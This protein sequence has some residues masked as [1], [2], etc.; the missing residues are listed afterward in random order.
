ME[1]IQPLISTPI[2]LSSSLWVVPFKALADH[3]LFLLT[4]VADPRSWA[5]GTKVIRISTV[6]AKDFL[7][8]LLF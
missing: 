5:C 7:F 1:E 8:L 2:I 4:D 6:A 3:M